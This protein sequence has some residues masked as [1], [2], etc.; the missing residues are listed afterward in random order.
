MSASEPQISLEVSKALGI[1]VRQKIGR[2][3]DNSHDAVGIRRAQRV[4][5]GDA[6]Q[7]DGRR[8]G[9]LRTS[10]PVQETVSQA[11]RPFVREADMVID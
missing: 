2:A 9:R 8:R 1:A 3:A 11:R 5:H 6:G 4:D 10:E 7:I